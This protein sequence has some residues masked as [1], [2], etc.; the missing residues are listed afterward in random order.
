MIVLVNVVLVT[1][2]LLV[3]MLFH[4]IHTFYART[5]DSQ[6]NFTQM[7]RQTLRSKNSQHLTLLV[8]L[9]DNKLNTIHQNHTQSFHQLQ[10]NHYV[11]LLNINSDGKLFKKI[12][13]SM[14]QINSMK[15]WLQVQL[16]F[17][18]QLNLLNI[19]IRSTNTAKK[20]VNAHKSYMI[21]FK[22]YNMV[23]FQMNSTGTLLLNEM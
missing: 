14:T 17:V 1:L 23:Q 22:V 8:Q 20:L 6:L 4:F 5:W 15:L 19:R 16:L 10:T 13:M 21:L 9:K 2:R 7:L 18:L 12:S 11:K 3:T